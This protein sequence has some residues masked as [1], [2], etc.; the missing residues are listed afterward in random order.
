MDAVSIR[1]FR[2]DDVSALTGMLHRAYAELGAMGLNFTAVD[3]DEPTTLRRASGGE[4]WVVT[5]GNELVAAMTMTF[6]PEAALQDISQEA[7]LP[8]RVW[9]NQLAV[10][11]T[12]RGRGLAGRL[13]VQGAAWARSAGASHVGLDTA[14][15][16]THLISLYSRWGFQG[17]E[18]V[19]WPGKTYES[20]IMLLAL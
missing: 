4:S 10:D 8:N 9:L 15:P 16:A 12:F 11:P 1:R 17:R 18:T 5:S 7:A 13:W 14:V 6:P 19:R 20:T 2:R 3:Q